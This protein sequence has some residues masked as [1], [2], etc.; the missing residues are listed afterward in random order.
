MQDLTNPE[1]YHANLKLVVEKESF[2]AEL[3]KRIDDFD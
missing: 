2:Y 3:K 1:K